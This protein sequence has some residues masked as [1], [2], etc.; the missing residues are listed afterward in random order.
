MNASSP[1]ASRGRWLVTS[2]LPY[3]NGPIHFGHVAGAYL[4]ADIFVRYLR[5]K[6]EDVAYICGTDEHGVAIT[7]A[8]EKAGTKPREYVD[9]WHR[10]IKETF[11]RLQIS[12]D[13]FSR[14]TRIHHYAVS[15]RVFKEILA[16]GYVHQRTEK[17]AYCPKCERFL[18]DR[19]LE[20]TCPHCG[21]RGSR[22]D[23]C[24][25]CGRWID[26]KA[27]V[28][29]RCK[30]CGSTPEE[31]ESTHWFLDLP[32]L[33]PK[34]TRWLETKTHW[35]DNVK[36]F[37]KAFLAEGLK[38]RPITRDLDW[39]VPVPLEGA[40]NKVLYV[41]FDAPIGYISATMEWAEKI[42]EPDRWKDFWLDKG[43]KLV[44]FIGKD[45]IPFHTIVF[46]AVLMAQNTPYVLPHDVP[47]NEFFN[48]EGHKFST[49]NAWTI[50]FDEF[51][52]KYPLDT[53]RYALAANAP[54][55]GDSE[56]TWSGFQKFVNSDLADTLGNLATRVLKFVQ[57]YCEGRVPP[58]GSPGE[59][60]RA[61][62][63][64]AAAA[65]AKVGESIAAYRMR[66]ALGEAMDLAR[67]ANKFLDDEE[68]WTTRT[69]DPARCGQTLNATSQVLRT[70]AVLFT[71]FIPYSAERLW[72]MLGLDGRP[73]DA[74]WDGA[75]ER[76]IA[77]GH[78][79]GT[80]EALFAKIED[81]AINAEVKALHDR[82][83][84]AGF[85]VS[86]AKT[87][88]AAKPEPGAKAPADA[89][90]DTAS[91]GPKP[92]KA[93]I[94]YDEFDRLDLRVGRILEAEPVPKADKLM[95]LVV[96]I[97]AERRQIIAGIRARYAPEELVGKL[98]VVL[99]NLKAKKLRGFESQ[100]MI[101]AADE[102]GL[103]T[104]LS[105][106]NG[107]LEGTVVK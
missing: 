55:S 82:A 49:S 21:A 5:M 58:L 33:Q 19:Y 30:I 77:D 71:P 84:A 51:L 11:E 64:A 85:D 102:N 35:R 74:P 83:K 46:P 89:R 66:K 36:S 63:D 67:L 18:A 45:N 48:L 31:R 104:L 25:K 56:F 37:V 44:H 57:L 75:G 59:R 91:A 69:T 76:R 17:Q 34:L 8:A 6:G 86:S 10:H 41:W 65:P 39:G 99:A 106:G 29:P 81:K 50:D 16:N 60:A 40:C 52:K 94:E 7:L 98:V 79:I 1:S 70:L 43:T 90:G 47:A 32:K 15:Q 12:F 23:E 61:L 14:T 72:K 62:L 96:D 2:A 24:P 93:P 103:P 68:P 13:C 101:L 87:A 53:L 100:G 3:A 20:G 95:K 4:P 42:G 27:L 54:E 26:A 97:G 9:R 88:A 107:V 38:E 105:P 80:P 73:A 22:G 92:G 78:P 28:D